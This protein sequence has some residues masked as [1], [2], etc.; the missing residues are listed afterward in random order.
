MKKTTG[1]YRGMQLVDAGESVTWIV[2]IAWINYVNIFN[3]FYK[4]S[5]L[6][7]KFCET[8]QSLQSISI[9]TFIIK[10]FEIN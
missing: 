1:I 8:C 9:A 6:S 2:D 4:F 7:V 3:V 10:T 5:S